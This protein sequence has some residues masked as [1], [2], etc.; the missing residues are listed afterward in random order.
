M[1]LG[2][3]LRGLESLLCVTVAKWCLNMQGCCAL[4]LWPKVVAKLGRRKIRGA[5][6]VKPEKALGDVKNDKRGLVQGTRDACDADR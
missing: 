5:N 1:L 6:R 3:D 2:F 4:V